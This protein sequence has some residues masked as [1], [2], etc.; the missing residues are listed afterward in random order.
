MPRRP[1]AG[2]AVRGT[3]PAGHTVDATS[4]PNRVSWEGTCT[5]PGCGLKVKAKRVPSERVPAKTAPPAPPAKAAAAGPGN[6]KLI[7]TRTPDATSR[8]KPR[9]ARA[10]GAPADPVRASEPGGVRGPGPDG[11]PVAVKPVE[12][13]HHATQ[14][15]RDR[16]GKWRESLAVKLHR[17]KQ[18]ERGDDGED[19]FDGIY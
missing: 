3:C 7:V 11:V 4:S 1:T 10:A 2:V 5:H 17:G 16:G 9:S 14:Q 8:P 18:R 15:A 19:L 12:G 6:R 13:P